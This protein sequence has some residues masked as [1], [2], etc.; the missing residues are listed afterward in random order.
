MATLNVTESPYN[1]AGDGS[2]DDTSAIQ[3]AIDD[4]G[5]GDTVYLPANTY[6]ISKAESVE[7]ESAIVADSSRGNGITDVTIHGD[8]SGTA[9]KMDVISD[10]STFSTVFGIR[11][12]SQVTGLVI[13]D[14]EVDGNRPNQPDVNGAG[15]FAYDSGGTGNDATIRDVRVRDS[16]RNNIAVQPDGFLLERCT[17]LDAGRHG[18]SLGPPDGSTGNLTVSKCLSKRS[19]QEVSNTYE[20]DFGAGSAVIKDCVFKNSNGAGWKTTE[21]VDTVT[22]RRIR[23]EGH[24]GLGYNHT[25]SSG[26]A[27]VTFEDIVSRNNG[28][29]GLRM[30]SGSVAYTV[31]GGT[32]I[33]SYNNGNNGYLVNDT[34]LDSNG[35][36]YAIDNA[37]RSLYASGSSGTV[38]EF[39]KDGNGGSLREDGLTF[40][41]IGSTRKTDLSNVPTESEVGAWSGGG[42]GGGSRT[43][44]SIPRPRGGGLLVTGG[45]TGYE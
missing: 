23:N 36:M 39:D 45:G 19:A 9:I 31:A 5:A 33:V 13:R 25:G 38:D 43:H 16:I 30:S 18:F 28:S 1:A 27:D 8:G 41:A 14:L 10:T 2:T 40:T 3:S 12:K 21:R 15:L 29:H 42:G 11:C 6:L 17:A 4:A 37:S 24:S 44:E 35:I 34:S 20:M 7:T 26:N 32:E 22:F